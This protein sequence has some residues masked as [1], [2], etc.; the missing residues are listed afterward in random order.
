MARRQA[1]AGGNC[2]GAL[3]A[4]CGPTI[5]TGARCVACAEASAAL[6]ALA[7][8]NCSVAHVEATCQG[9]AAAASPLARALPQELAPYMW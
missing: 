8:A 2:N 4:R 6:P 1:A 7:A 5:G 3:V 9:R